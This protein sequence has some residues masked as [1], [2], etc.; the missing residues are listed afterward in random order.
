M[1]SDPVRNDPTS[2]EIRR[3][4]TGEWAEYRDV[5]LRALR[6]DPLAFG[7]TLAREEGFAEQEWTDR[8]QRGACAADGSKFVARTSTGEFV[9]LIA[10]AK[11]RDEWHV[12]EM[13]TDPAWRRRGVGGRLLDAALAWFR[14][15]AP[16]ERLQLDVNPRQAAAERLYRSRGFRRTGT[17]G[18]L[19]HTEGETVVAMVLVAEGPTT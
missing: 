19:G 8:T 9:G 13:W 14:Q 11:Y 4:R 1:S 2:V 3:I 17:S 12:F 16:G 10:V 7:S 15:M 5:R 6:S 18:P